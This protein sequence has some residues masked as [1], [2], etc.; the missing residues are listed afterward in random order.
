LAGFLCLGAVAA[1]A[2]ADSKGGER[3]S[4]GIR[5]KSAGD[6]ALVTEAPADTP[7][8]RAGVRVGDSIVAF[9]GVRFR[10]DSDLAL[11]RGLDWIR[12]GA[13]VELTI[14]RHGEESRVVVTPE[15]FSAAELAALEDWLERAAKTA[16]VQRRACAY[17]TFEKMA[18]Y[19]GIDVEFRK[20][21]KGDTFSMASKRSL[22]PDLDLS[23]PFLKGLVAALRAGD[24]LTMHYVS[25]NGVL[26]MEVVSAP[27]YLDVRRIERAT[28][29]A[30][31][32]PQ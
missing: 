25:K 26:H 16:E 4:L 5:I 9:N 23:D 8:G 19:P 11:I 3:G 1:V 18:V 21:A 12:P 32:S 29:P 13:P 15:R 28:I 17:G 22:P 31:R 10:F 24:A 6:R 30:A 20:A 7:G 2:G 27:E 14:S